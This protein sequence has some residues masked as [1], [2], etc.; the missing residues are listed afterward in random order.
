MFSDTDGVR[1]VRRLRD[2]R[3]GRDSGTLIAR[4]GGFRLGTAQQVPESTLALTIEESQV[5]VNAVSL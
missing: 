2:P 3:V 5:P 4:R 1:V